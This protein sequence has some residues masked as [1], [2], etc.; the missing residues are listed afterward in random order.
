MRK[1][2]FIFVLV[3]IF[4]FSII[5]ASGFQ[6]SSSSYTSDNRADSFSNTNAT[7]TSF[8]QRFIGGIKIVGQYVTNTFTGRFGILD[9]KLNLIINVT[10]PTQGGSV[11]RGNDATSGEDD[12]GFIP[13]SINLTGRLLDNYNAGFSGATCFF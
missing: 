12:K 3:L 13:N 11:V 7:S 2:N 4:L 5:L 10:Y 8:T 9:E 6:G 1:L